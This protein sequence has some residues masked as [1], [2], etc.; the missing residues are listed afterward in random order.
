MV[1]VPAL[2]GL[3]GDVKIIEERVC[4][5]GAGPPIL[6]QHLKIGS[7][8]RVWRRCASS[9][10]VTAREKPEGARRTPTPF[11]QR[12]SIQGSV[13]PS[14]ALLIFPP[15]TNQH[16]YPLLFSGSIRPRHPCIE[17][18]IP[19]WFNRIRAHRL[20]R[21]LHLL[22]CVADGNTRRCCHGCGSI[23]WR[24][25]AARHPISG[26]AMADAYLLAGAS[27]DDHPSG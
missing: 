2:R 27:G 14:G 9:W 6:I 12:G 21:G 19:H 26:D 16:S 7:S 22:R 11:S 23:R 3:R 17:T 24:W 4:D 13:R 20:K 5:A 10:R 25:S 15:V 1:R 8:A 18:L